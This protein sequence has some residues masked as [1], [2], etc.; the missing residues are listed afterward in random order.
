MA[1]RAAVADRDETCLPNICYAP[2]QLPLEC[3]ICCGNASRETNY[4]EYCFV[5]NLSAFVR[6][7]I[8]ISRAL[9]KFYVV[10]VSRETSTH[11]S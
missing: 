4:Q 2:P 11:I 8:S 7:V 3:H 6:G 5:M 10:C 1:D 9:Y